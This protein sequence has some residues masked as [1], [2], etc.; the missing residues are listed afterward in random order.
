MHCRWY[1]NMPCRFPGPHPGG[2][3]RG[4]WPGGIPR[5]TTKGEVEGIWPGGSPG[6]HL[7][8]KLRRIWPGGSPGPHLRGKLRRIWPG[9]LQA[10][11]QGGLLPGGCLLQGVWRPPHDGYC[12]RQY[13]SY[14]NAFLFCKLLLHIIYDI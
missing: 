9:G 4:I 1:P 11:T 8:G 14:W 5:P 10:H 12:C 7:R 6:P 2:K 3:L 13:A